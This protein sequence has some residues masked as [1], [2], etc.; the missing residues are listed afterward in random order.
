M[1]RLLVETARRREHENRIRDADRIG[2]SVQIGVDAII[3]LSVVIREGVQIGGVGTGCATHFGEPAIGPRT[4]AH[5]NAVIPCPSPSELNLV[6]LRASAQIRD[7]PVIDENCSERVASQ[8]LQ[9]Q[10]RVSEGVGILDTHGNRM[11]A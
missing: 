3:V 7:E 8:V 11:C 6:A 2:P 5:D 1:R 4:A 10:A 9:P